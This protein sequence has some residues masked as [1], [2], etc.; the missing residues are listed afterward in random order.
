M[1]ICHSNAGNWPEAW[2]R[3]MELNT[4]SRLTPEAKDDWDAMAEWM[5]MRQTLFVQ[6]IH[7]DE[8]DS[9]FVAELHQM[10]IEKSGTW[11]GRAAMAVLNIYHGGNYYLYPEDDGGW[12]PRKMSSNNGKMN[13]SG[14]EVYPNPTD[15]YLN[16]V[17]T[18]KIPSNAGIVLTVFGAT[19][20]TIEQ[21]TMTDERMLLDTRQW[22]PG[23]YVIEVRI[24][25]NEPMKTKVNVVH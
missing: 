4:S 11:A 19:G 2:N 5:E 14:L 23:L 10:A 16:V 9:L 25:G 12:E 22:S 7:W 13:S 21:H 1:A 3:H 24:A 18:E 6:E 8:A 17:I 20:K 15:V